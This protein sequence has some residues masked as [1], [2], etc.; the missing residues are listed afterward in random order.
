MRKNR[1]LFGVALLCLAATLGWFF[2]AIFKRFGEGGSGPPVRAAEQSATAESGQNHSTLEAAEHHYTAVPPRTH[3]GETQAGASA[4]KETG[5]M[6]SVQEP[7]QRQ[8]RAQA[9]RPVQPQDVEVS[10]EMGQIVPHRVTT[11]APAQPH[12]IMTLP[13]GVQPDDVEFSPDADVAVPR[14]VNGPPQTQSLAA[15]EGVAV[16]GSDAGTTQKSKKAEISPQ[17]TKPPQ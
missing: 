6:P 2:R 5:A 4:K 1:I 17:T 3:D 13:P 14:R 8:G 10:L 7:W 15:A 9:P 16:P 11:N 12:P